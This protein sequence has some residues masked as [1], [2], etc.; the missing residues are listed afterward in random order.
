M[1]WAVRLR[2]WAH[3]CPAPQLRMLGCSEPGE[4]GQRGRGADRAARWQPSPAGRALQQDG[5]LRCGWG[6][7][8]EKA[9][10]CGSLAA[11]G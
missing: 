11:S 7:E 4:R 6:R 9:L 2:C 3:E 10:G 8:L 1:D 5:G